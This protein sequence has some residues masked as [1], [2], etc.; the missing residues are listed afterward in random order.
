[1]SYHGSTVVVLC[2]ELGWSN[3]LE[4]QLHVEL[5]LIRTFTE[6]ALKFVL[7]FVFF[8]NLLF[9]L[10]MT[11]VLSFQRPRFEHTVY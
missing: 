9:S 7:P 1:M 5:E 2:G 8:C 3:T 11:P 10:S 6:S 4:V